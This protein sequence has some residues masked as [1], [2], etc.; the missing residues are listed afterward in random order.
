MS[1]LEITERV[2]RGDIKKIIIQEEL[3][4]DRQPIINTG[5]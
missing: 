5:L 1:N 3:R 4:N 2:D